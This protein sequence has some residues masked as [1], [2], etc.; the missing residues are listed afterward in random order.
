MF[1]AIG[2]N[3]LF[4]DRFANAKL[5]SEVKSWILPL[6][7]KRMKVYGN[8]YLLVGDAASLI[9]PFSGEGIGNG[10]T[11]GKI[12]AQVISDALQKN[13]FTENTLQAYQKALFGELGRSLDTSYK[14]QMLGRNTFL[15]NWVIDKAARSP[16]VQEYISAALINPEKQEQFYSPLFYLKLLLS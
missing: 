2:S 14:L 9:D 12:A 1:D 16:K 11:S 4:K 5:A 7:S 10:L 3:P 13:D 8:G 15:L 6:G